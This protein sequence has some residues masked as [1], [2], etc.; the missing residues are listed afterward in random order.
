M[1]GKR[2]WGLGVKDLGCLNKALLSKW[3]WRFA[4][5]WNLVI[6][7]KYGEE[8]VVWCRTVESSPQ[9]V[10]RLCLLDLLLL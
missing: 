9:L 6:R 5:L 10:A 8:G 1:L 7:A 3:C 4:T 2:E